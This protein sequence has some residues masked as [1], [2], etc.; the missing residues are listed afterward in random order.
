MLDGN[1][2]LCLLVA[3]RSPLSQITQPPLSSAKEQNKA[4]KYA[5]C[6]R[7]N[8]VDSQACY[9]KQGIE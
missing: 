6:K 5:K 1:E 8:K 3:D 7:D 2:Y 4:T 9:E